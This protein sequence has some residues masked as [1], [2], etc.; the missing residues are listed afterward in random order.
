MVRVF[1]LFEFGEFAGDL[2]L[3]CCVVGKRTD[4]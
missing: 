1:V 4:C 3:D 2:M